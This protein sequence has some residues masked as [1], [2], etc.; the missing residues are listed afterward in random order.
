MTGRAQH[1]TTR[2]VCRTAYEALAARNLFNDTSGN[3]ADVFE[4]TRRGGKSA[5]LPKLGAGPSQTGPAHFL[6]AD[7]VHCSL[8]IS[9]GLVS[10]VTS[11]SRKHDRNGDLTHGYGKITHD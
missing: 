8:G 11:S 4:L 9:G 6:E 7:H 5:F 2:P 10:F 3:R 1:N